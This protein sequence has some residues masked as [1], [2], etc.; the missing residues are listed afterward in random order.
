M[1]KQIQQAKKPSKIRQ[2]WLNIGKLV[3]DATKLSFGSLVLGAAIKG[4]IPTSTLM[5]MGVA[6]S[7]GGAVIGISLVTLFE[8]K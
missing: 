2:L 3:L 5:L 6:I 4:E 8:E 7:V 1:A